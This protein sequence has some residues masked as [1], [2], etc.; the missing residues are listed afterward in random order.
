MANSQKEALEV[1]TALVPQGVFQRHIILLQVQVF[2]GLQ[3][4]LQTTHLEQEI[5]TKLSTLSLPLVHSLRNLQPLA[6][7]Q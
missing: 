6:V 2:D 7:K 3:I 4:K 1:P 5:K